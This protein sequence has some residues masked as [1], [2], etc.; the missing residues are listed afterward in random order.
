[1]D[2]DF[3]QTEGMDQ[4][5]KQTEGMDQDFK[6]AE[7]SKGMGVGPHFVALGKCGYIAGERFRG[8]GG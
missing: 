8:G 7:L 4:D 2:Q 1:M 5:F 3:K 6:Q